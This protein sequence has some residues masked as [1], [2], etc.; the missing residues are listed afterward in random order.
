MEVIEARKRPPVDPREFAYPFTDEQIERYL[1]KVYGKII[2]T[3]SLDLKY[4][5]TVAI[6]LEDALRH[7]FEGNLQ[8]F[9]VSSTE[10]QTYKALRDNIYKFS[11]AKQYQQVRIMSEFINRKGEKSTFAEFKELAGK[12]FKEYNEQYLKTEYVT[13]I[14]QSQAARDWVETWDRKDL[15]PFLEYRTQRDSHVRDEHAAL[16]GITLPVTHPFWKTYHPK[17]GFRCRCFT[18]QHERKKVTD[19]NLRDLSDLDDEKKFPKIFRM[20]PGRDKMIFHEGRH[21][22]FSVARGDKE[23][24]QHN[25]KMPI[26]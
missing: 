17:N 21:P 4:H 25:F 23:L 5:E 22:Y 20:N 2:T 8:S 12:V 9:V 10:Y 6:T 1:L 15:M 7:G 3:R 11:A 18:V 16:D 24:K 19:L 13:A 26:P 14:G